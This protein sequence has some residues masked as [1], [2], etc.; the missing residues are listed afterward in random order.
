[1]RQKNLT[2]QYLSPIGLSNIMQYC[3]IGDAYQQLQCIL[4]V[5]ISIRYQAGTMNT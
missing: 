2:S 4:V 1:V 5:T 3:L